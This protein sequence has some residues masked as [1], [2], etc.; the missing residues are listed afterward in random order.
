MTRM[1]L[2]EAKY[3]GWGEMKAKK[4]KTAYNFP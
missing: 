4:D 1:L 2:E 3:R